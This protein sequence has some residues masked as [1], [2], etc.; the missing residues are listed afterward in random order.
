MSRLMTSGRVWLRPLWPG[1]I[2]MLAPANTETER[3]G[4]GRGV[5]SAAVVDTDGRGVAALGCSFAPGSGAASA[6]QAE[7]R[8]PVTTLAAIRRTSRP[9]T[10]LAGSRRSTG[11]HC[12]DARAAAPTDHGSARVRVT[13]GRRV[14]GP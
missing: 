13:R 5:G 12:R 7:S 9:D 11:A 6:P 2:P 1:S 14:P 3:V 4:T 8:A 10:A